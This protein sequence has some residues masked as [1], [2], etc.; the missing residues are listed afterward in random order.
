M[1]LRAGLPRF[2]AALALGVA[3]ARLVAC[4]DDNTLTLPGQ[5]GGKRHN[6]YSCV[7]GPSQTP[8]LSSNFTQARV[9]GS[10]TQGLENR[11]NGFGCPYVVDY[12]Q[13]QIWIGVQVTEPVSTIDLNN[14]YVDFTGLIS[15][16]TGTSQAPSSRKFW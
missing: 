5:G 11:P 15:K 2:A 16:W 9:A 3:C 4:G 10:F 7:I 1:R 8:I 6:P 13:E 14:Q 12:N